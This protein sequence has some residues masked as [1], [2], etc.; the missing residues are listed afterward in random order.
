MTDVHKQ[1]SIADLDLPPKRGRPKSGN[2]LSNRDKQKLYRERAKQLGKK[3]L[4]I[5][6]FEAALME[7]MISH[8]IVALGDSDPAREVYV[9]IRRKFQQLM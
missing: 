4:L 1:L 3:H 6:P 7:S 2:A 5:E 9:Q 8:H